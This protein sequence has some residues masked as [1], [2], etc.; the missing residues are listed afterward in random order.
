MHPSDYVVALT[1][2]C[3]S[4]PSYFTKSAVTMAPAT[5][6]SWPPFTRLTVALCCFGVL[7]LR[8]LLPSSGRLYN[9]SN[10]WN[11]HQYKTT[12]EHPSMHCND[13]NDV[14]FVPSPSLGS[15]FSHT[16]NSN[17][18]NSS[19]NNSSNNSSKRFPSIETVIEMATLS[20]LIYAFH[21]EDYGN[22]DVNNTVCERI[23]RHTRHNKMNPSPPRPNN[24][25][26][27]NIDATTATL[28]TDTTIN[29]RT[30][31]PNIHCEWYHHDWIDGTQIMIVSSSPGSM[32]RPPTITIIFAGTDDMT[33]SLTD[34]NVLLSPFG[35]PT[36]GFIN[37]TNYPRYNVTL[38]DPNIRVHTG[39]DT[40]LFNTRN[41]FGE[42]VTRVEQIRRRL[43]MSPN[44]GHHFAAGGGASRSPQ[45][46]TTGHS[47]GG[48]YSILMAIGLTQYYES[49]RNDSGHNLSTNAPVSVP[50][51]MTVI[52]FGCP[53]IGNV[54]F[55]DYIHTNPSFP[56]QRLHI[57]RFVLGWDIVPRL[58]TLLQHVGH[59]I[60]LSVS[61]SSI[62]N[63]LRGSN[64]GSRSTYKNITTAA[65]YHHIGNVTLQYS[66]VPF[67]WSATPF[68]WIPGAVT[69]HYITAYIQC[70]YDLRQQLIQ[71][72]QQQQHGRNDTNH[73]N[74]RNE[75]HFGWINDFER[76]S[77]VPISNDTVYDDD[78]YIEPPNDDDVTTT[79]AQN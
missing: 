17:N 49:L 77:S 29:N 62:R 64:S 73:Q 12:F 68:I 30:V 14:H 5:W 51:E 1:A 9:N 65:Y 40:T 74:V 24:R 53:Q 45:L 35:Y 4:D 55:R 16:K 79:L 75:T 8:L 28:I 46:Y 3:D 57:Y 10:S 59:T 52:N 27:N 15:G 31:P 21:M 26:H 54:A 61:K 23:N 18:N 63:D 71:Q 48:G 32:D 60:Q 69:A 42:I 37:T 2:A 70:L 44:D 36:S 20:S 38:P 41:L 50:E 56:N 25:F 43:T 22:D 66:S 6:W 13:R 72:Q 19:K 58:P 33:T 76:S 67:G 78:Y 7:T 11:R 34:V 39:F 47:L